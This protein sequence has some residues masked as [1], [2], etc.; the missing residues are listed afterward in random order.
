MADSEAA[1]KFTADPEQVV[2]TGARVMTTRES[3]AR[4]EASR[5]AK[6][7]RQAR[8]AS[9]IRNLAGPPAAAAPALDSI[10]VAQDAALSI[11]DWLQRIRERR[12]SGALQAARDSLQD[13]VE[14]HP[15][16]LL[17]DDLRPLLDPP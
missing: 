8:R 17:P 10:P 11:E 1:M 6:A 5:Q 3:A 4:A 9:E 2:V 7:E 15:E 12:D 13:F 14:A 16:H